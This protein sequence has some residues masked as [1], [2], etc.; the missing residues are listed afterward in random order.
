M[1]I[2]NL[3]SN[4]ILITNLNPLQFEFS[5][6]LYHK[7]IKKSQFVIEILYLT[8]IDDSMIKSKR[9]EL[10]NN[11]SI[12]ILD[13]SLTKKG[14]IINELCINKI[15]YNYKNHDIIFSINN[16][17]LSYKRYIYDMRSEIING[18]KKLNLLQ[19]RNY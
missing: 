5:E 4:Y 10:F 6:V 19:Y 1:A 18:F 16:V 2:K 13:N 15:L 8:T 9:I 17:N 3:K 12:T 11:F 7:E 14:L